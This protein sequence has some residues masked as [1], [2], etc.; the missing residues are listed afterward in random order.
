MCIIPQT[1][2][3]QDSP[4]TGGNPAGTYLFLHMTQ[5]AWATS[6]TRFPWPKTVMT[7]L[8]ICHFNDVYRVTP[9]KISRTSS[10]TV[11]VTQ[12]AALLHGL[13][14]QWAQRADGK[15]DGEHSSD[16]IIRIWLTPQSSGLV[17]FSGDVFSPST[18]S[19][20]TRGSHMV[21]CIPSVIPLT[22]I[23]KIWLGTYYEWASS[24]RFIDR[25]ALLFCIFSN[26]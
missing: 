14:D 4:L 17:L 3:Q 26:V 11:D 19:S 16:L 24:W 6:S 12:F 13:R 21:L 7:T 18:E 23:L 5:S 8:P 25:W 22:R 1:G 20:V 2:I 10:E 15:R 9:Q